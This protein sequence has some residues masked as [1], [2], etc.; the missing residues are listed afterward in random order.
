[1][2]KFRLIRTF[3]QNHGINILPLEET[4]WKEV[5]ERDIDA[6]NVGDW[7]SEDDQFNKIP[8]VKLSDLKNQ[9]Q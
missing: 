4:I 9:I 6:I 1:M 3:L 8:Y 2:N 7:V 5:S